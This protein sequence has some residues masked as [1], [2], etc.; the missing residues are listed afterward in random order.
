[1]RLPDVSLS[2]LPDYIAILFVR[3]LTKNLPS[4]PPSK[5]ASLISL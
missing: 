3:I 2:T 5:S 4:R 1:M